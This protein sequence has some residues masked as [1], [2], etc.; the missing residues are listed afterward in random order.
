MKKMHIIILPLFLSSPF[1]LADETIQ[2]MSDPLAIYTQAGIGFSNHGVNLKVGATYN[3]GVSTEVGM[4]I[5]E[6]KGIAGDAVGWSGSSERN[7]S[8]D[9]I[10]YRNFEVDLTNGRG[11]QV[12]VNY[13]T[14]T[15]S[16]AQE[17]GTMSYSMIQ[18]LPSFGPV[19]LFP[20][21]GA[22][23]AFGNNLDKAGLTSSDGYTVPG[24]LAVV[25]TYSKITLTDKIWLNYNP[26]Y[27]MTLSGTDAFKDHFFEN[28]DSVLVHEFTASYQFNP[29]FNVRYFANWSEN[30]DIAD[31]AHRIEFNYQF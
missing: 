2:D 19:T 4:N 26:M 18:A 22:G 6:V 21:A 30:V 5:F 13:A 27:M 17:I 28:S 15:N 12:D 8:I 20:L 14:A 10:R 3:T 31:G 1:V 7:N 16:G 9:S 11:S 23:F 24:T 29:R 25:G